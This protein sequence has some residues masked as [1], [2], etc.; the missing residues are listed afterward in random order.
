MK[1]LMILD[2]EFPPDMRVEKEALSL[3]NSGHKVII[4]CYSTNKKQ[5][6]EN[7]KSI[8]VY[9]FQINKILRNKLSGLYLILPFYRK[10]WE[11]QIKKIIKTN[12][13]NI[14]H[15]HDLPL[16]DVGVKLKKQFGYKLICDQHE[17]YSNWIV[18]TDTYNKFPGN[19]IKHL[20]NWKKFEKDY[21][22]QSD[23]VIT[24]EE[25]LKK[26]YIENIG[27]DPNKII[28][29]PNT[30]LKSIFNEKNIKQE[31]VKKYQ[32]H[33][34]IFYAGGID[35]LRGIDIIIASLKLIKS[36]IPNIKFVFAG[37]IFKGYNPLKHAEELGVKDLIEFLGFLPINEIPSYIAG[38]D[39]CV[40]IP[41]VN[42]EEINKTIA[43]KIYQYLVMKKPIIVSQAK[44]MQEFVISNK[45]G[46][47]IDEY[48]KENFAEKV[49]EIYN[50]P[51]L[52]KKISENA[53]LISKN[54]Y[55]EKTSE[56]LIGMYNEISEK[57]KGI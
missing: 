5:S 41:P 44:L 19:I 25:P 57:Y 43:T 27:I 49:L 21:L 3:I 32:K 12:K 6:Y 54:Y 55:W 16:C 42:R 39:V 9:R 37:K 40:F 35:I 50:N 47:V 1:I 24:I 52:R 8:V 45:V 29:I 56:V 15:I 10:L 48:S 53:E 7:Y 34:V 31:I 22:P 2:G 26:I 30:P 20:S 38:S 46:L 17:Y 4:L 13:I 33:F 18:H 28:C 23:L 11:Y 36:K 14:L 51:N